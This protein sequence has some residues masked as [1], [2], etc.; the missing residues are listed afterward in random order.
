VKCQ[1]FGFDDGPAPT[2]P[3]GFSFW[4]FF[5]EATMPEVIRT[6]LVG[7][8]KDNEDGTNRQKLIK[9]YLRPGTELQLLR[10][11]DNPFDANATSAWISV[12]GKAQRVGY[13]STEL[14]NDRTD[15]FKVG[16]DATMIVLDVT[17][18][19]RDKPSIGVNVQITFGE[20]LTPTPPKTPAADP[21][22]W[23]RYRRGLVHFGRSVANLYQ[24]LASRAVA[25]YGRL[26]SWAQPIVWGLGLGLAILVILLIARVVRR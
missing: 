11:I 15:L 25:A 9:K 6:K 20:V 26:P 5:E 13:V 7:V 23:D 2:A 24:E 4:P 12:K 18:G 21:I 3:I 14:V 16:R 17:G 1:A 22:D 8:T 10:E 19:T